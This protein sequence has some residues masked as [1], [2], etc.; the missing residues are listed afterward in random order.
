MSITR[1][2]SRISKRRFSEDLVLTVWQKPETSNQTNGSL[3]RTFASKEVWIK[4]YTLCDTWQLPLQDVV[5]FL[6]LF[7]SLDREFA[8]AKCRY[9]GMEG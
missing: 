5:L 3:Q 1:G 6:Y 7:F 9:G 4:G 8:R 2:I